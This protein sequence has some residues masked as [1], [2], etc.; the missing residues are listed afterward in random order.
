MNLE[1][2]CRPSTRHRDPAVG[3]EAR[4]VSFSPTAAIHKEHKA[5]NWN[6]LAQFA[7]AVQTKL[8][9]ADAGTMSGYKY[10]V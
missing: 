6:T 5:S 2:L 3:A 9:A 10:A 7:D 1:F 8:G 4:T